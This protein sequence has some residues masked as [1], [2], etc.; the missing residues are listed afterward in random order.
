MPRGNLRDSGSAWASKTSLFL[1]IFILILAPFHG[2]VVG[3]SG[4]PIDHIIVLCEENRT[5]DNYFGTYPGANGF[6]GNISLHIAPFSNVTVSPYHLSTTTTHDLNHAHSTAMVAYDNGR[7]DGFIYAEQS[8]LAM[9][10]YDFRD[11]PY[12]WDYAS[13]FVLMDNFFSS[14]MGPGLPN[15]L[16]LIAGQ[17]GT[18][19]E[20]AENF[21]LNFRVVMDE[22]D[23]RG[24]SWKYYTD[25]PSGYTQ[26]GVWNPL[27]AFESFKTNQ[28]RF[29]NLASN[30]QFLTD[31]GAGNLAS[32]VW[33]V[34]KDEDSEHPPSDIAVGEH[35]VVSLVNAIMQSKYWSSTAIF[36][37]WD[38]YGGWYDHVP[39]PQID[40]FGLGFR[41][42]CLVISPYSRE[43]YIYNIQSDFCSILKFIETRYSIPPLTQRDAITNDMLEA[44]DFSQQP[45]EPLIL[46]GPYVSDH[47][48]LTLAE[49]QSYLNYMQIIA[50]STAITIAIVLVVTFLV[51]KRRK[52]M[53][54]LSRKETRP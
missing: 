26:E 30:D 4:I 9:G 19:Y 37:T 25:G 28:S 29:K 22:L 2:A 27:P 46:P 12:Y 50:V 31:V 3:Q 1:L 41:V 39:P 15:H 24:I 52:R 45:R 42:P 54:S 32:V 35:Y 44:F 8:A 6:S 23:A 5:F 48:P 43:G 17:S 14:E 53:R 51:L 20:N 38:D 11:I 7:M 40:S 33:I 49:N 10:Y 13:K 36:L 34:P 21:S 47:Y 18:L 16:Y